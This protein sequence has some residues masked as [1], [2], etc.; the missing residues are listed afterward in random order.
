MNFSVRLQISVKCT[1]DKADEEEELLNH[2]EQ[3][4]ILVDFLPS[5]K[6]QQPLLAGVCMPIALCIEYSKIASDRLG[7]YFIYC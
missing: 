4:K 5:T 7:W 1:Q 2:G 6:P 3:T